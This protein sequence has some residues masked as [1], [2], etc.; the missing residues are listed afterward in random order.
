MGRRVGKEGAL[1]GLDTERDTERNTQ[2][3]WDQL[4]VLTRAHAHICLLALEFALMQPNRCIF[5][6]L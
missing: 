2:P 6:H 5:M 3:F 4:P 1:F